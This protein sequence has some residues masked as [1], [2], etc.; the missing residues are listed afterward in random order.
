MYHLFYKCACGATYY[1]F[2]E[3]LM[4]NIL[5]EEVINCTAL[6]CAACWSALPPIRVGMKRNFHQIPIEPI[7]H[8][9]QLILYTW[10]TLTLCKKEFKFRLK[11][12]WVAAASMLV[13]S[14]SRSGSWQSPQAALAAP[15]ALAEQGEGEGEGHHCDGGREALASLWL[16]GTWILGS[17]SENFGLVDTCWVE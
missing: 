10:L 1:V 6:R 12:S 9:I 13:S 2:H 11:M 4:R 5:T 8:H 7:P 3:G 15:L 14:G 17:L 16:W